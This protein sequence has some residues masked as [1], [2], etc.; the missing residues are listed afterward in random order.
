MGG[1][2]GDDAIDLGFESDGA[3]DVAWVVTE[4]V[5]EERLSAPYELRA[6]L[7]TEAADAEPV[8]LLG[9]AARLV[10]R[11]G[12]EARHVPGIVAAVGEPEQDTTDR[13]RVT[14]IVRPA[15]EALRH[16]VDTRIFQGATVPEILLEVLGA[17]L[18]PYGRGVEDRTARSYRP[19]DFRV[20]YDESDL[21]FCHRLMEEEGIGYRFELE[22]DAE[23][24]VLLDDEGELP[25]VE[26][27]GP[28]EFGHSTDDARHAQIG[29]F[30]VRSRLRPTKLSTRH[31]D[32]RAPSTPLEGESTEA[33]RSDSR[34]GAV[35]E[36]EREGYDHDARPLTLEPGALAYGA[37]KADQVRIR[38]E[39]QAH[40]ARLAAGTSSAL[41]LT[42]GAT[43]ELTGHPRSDLDG[44]Y[45]LVGVTHRFGVDERAYQNDFT[46]IP[47]GTPHRPPRRTPKPRVP[48]VQTATV[49]GPAGEEIHT[50]EHGRIK[51]QFHWDR[52]GA[53]DE[54]SSGWLRVR[55]P[56]AGAGWGMQF[57]PRIG[58]EVVVDFLDGDPDRPVVLGCVYNGDNAPPYPLPDDKTKSTIKTSS[59]LGGD[60]FNELRFEDLA[61]SEQIYLHA[62]KD[63]DE[64]VENDHT[65]TVHH[66]QRIR[67]DNDQ[68]QEV[69]VDQTEHV[70]ANQDL[71][72]D[73]NRTITVHGD[74]TETIDAGETRTVHSGVTET[75]DAGETRTV[76]G[77]M[78]E[79]IDGGR[80]QDITGSSTETVLGSLTETTD[81]GVTVT[82]PGSYTLTALGGLNI[83]A[84][85]G[86]TIQ[87]H[88]FTLIAPAG[89]THHDAFWSFLAKSWTDNFAWKLDVTPNSI[90][91]G[92]VKIS[93][94]VVAYLSTK[95]FK[96]GFDGLRAKVW[97]IN[98]DTKAE[99]A[100]AKA[101]DAELAALRSRA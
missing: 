45:L 11:L 53:R 43:F 21:D 79:T 70:F 7:Y 91:T 58:M 17:A 6:E 20:Q 96:G 99:V 41:A 74:F 81:G 5:F 69:G 75:I 10:I 3:P 13:L 19:C 64:V 27:S 18:G 12:D 39:R 77:G 25:A 93:G 94:T 50:D 14:V 66:D 87:T 30:T 2:S 80:T 85:G 73:V 40:D 97:T 49:V 90:D 82:T 101:V 78:T 62:Q 22:G 29:A 15:L 60:G 86:T 47:K 84:Q 32:W 28:I 38:R 76:D 63:L 8:R 54:R 92:G 37:D 83:T 61:G 67:V 88:T 68:R 9:K 95:G 42:H 71:T 33:P 4:A 34:H 16:R 36:P 89:N 57:I 72:V 65:T 44:G 46:A 48:S 100:E 23:T 52:L 35:I 24:L 26:S 51:A 56:W 1:P 98:G 31:Y 55:Q 59:S